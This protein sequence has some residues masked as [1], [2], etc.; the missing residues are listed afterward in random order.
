MQFFENEQH[1]LLKAFRNESFLSV[2]E[3]QTVIK[4]IF[5]DLSPR[6]SLVKAIMRMIAM[7]M[8]RNWK[9]PKLL[10]ICNIRNIKGE[11]ILNESNMYYNS[12][13]SQSMCEVLC[14]PSRAA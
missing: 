5:W 2:S 12:T 13:V 9:S 11:S 3:S 10:R 14:S 4:I 6:H 1:V 8:N 7:S